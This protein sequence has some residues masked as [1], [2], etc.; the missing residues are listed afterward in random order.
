MVKSKGKGGVM[1]N[2]VS[3]H[4]HMGKGSGTYEGKGVACR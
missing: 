4:M 1:G 2:G 3:H